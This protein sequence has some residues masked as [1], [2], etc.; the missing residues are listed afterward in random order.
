MLTDPL[1]LDI[2]SHTS[3]V[4]TNPIPIPPYF[5]GTLTPKNPIS[6][7]FSI[8]SSVSLKSLAS[9]RLFLAIT[10]LSLNSITEFI[11]ILCSSEKSSGVK[12]LDDS[13]SLTINSPPFMLIFSFIFNY[14]IN[15]KIPAA[16]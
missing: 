1:P 5:S 13:V 4:A 11:I 2:Y 9:N 16:P 3:I 12:T 8:T 6:P 7:A 10:S 15:S 14:F